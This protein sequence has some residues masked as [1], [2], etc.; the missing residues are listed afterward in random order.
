MLM[1]L[2][3]NGSLSSIKIYMI[4]AICMAYIFALQLVLLFLRQ[5]LFYFILLSQKFVLIF[6]IPYGLYKFNDCLFIVKKIAILAFILA[7]H[8][9]TVFWDKMFV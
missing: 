4:A 8:N 2:G 5:F 1:V 6:N 3:D 7:I 9:Y